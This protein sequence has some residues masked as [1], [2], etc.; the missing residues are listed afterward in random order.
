MLFIAVICT[1]TGSISS[2]TLRETTKRN[3]ARW[4]FNGGLTSRLLVSV[5]GSRRDRHCGFAMAGPERGGYRFRVTPQ[6]GSLIKL[7]TP[8]GRNSKNREQRPPVGGLSAALMILLKGQ[9]EL[10]R[11]QRYVRKRQ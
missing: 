6:R 4:F 10:V 7:N 9:N 2:P 8:T 5:D 11:F 1:V 3:C